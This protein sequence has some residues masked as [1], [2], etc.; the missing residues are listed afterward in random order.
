MVHLTAKNVAVMSCCFVA[1]VLLFSR[2]SNAD[3]VTL[4]FTGTATGSIGENT[5]NNATF[6]ITVL[7]DTDNVEPVPGFPNSIRI[8][9][10][11]ATVS[12]NGTV[13]QITPMLSV[14]SKK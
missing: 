14:F 12:I 10:D 2:I 13:S 6:D 5:F 1:G 4:K 7:G 11:S 8:L 3:L 9:S